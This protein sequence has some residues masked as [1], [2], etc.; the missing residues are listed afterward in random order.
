MLNLLLKNCC[1]IVVDN[2]MLINW[3]SWL[4][5]R[6]LHNTTSNTQQT[7]MF[8]QQFLIFWANIFE[9]LGA[10]IEGP[11]TWLLKTTKLKLRQSYIGARDANWGQKRRCGMQEAQWGHSHQAHSQ[12]RW[13]NTEIHCRNL[14]GTRAART[15]CQVQ[16]PRQ[17]NWRSDKLLITWSQIRIREKR[18]YQS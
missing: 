5:Y 14:H 16:L 13:R 8:Q 17:T 7:A 9:I 6:V 15:S 11:S 3:M 2:F 4:R 1:F 12:Q 10:S 18:N